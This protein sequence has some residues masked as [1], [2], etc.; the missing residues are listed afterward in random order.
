MRAPSPS[1]RCSSGGAVATEPGAGS[2]TE[3]WAEALAAWRIPPEVRAAAPED[4]HAFSPDLF[5][6]RPGPPPDTPTVRRVR[7]VL[8]ADGVLLDVGAAAGRLGLALCPPS[9]RLVA[10]DRDADALA[11]LR[12]DA[13]ARGIAVETVHGT[14]PE[15]AS[16]VEP[17]DVVLCAHV[18]YGV[19]DVAPFVQ[20]LRDRTLERLVL[21]VTAVHP[22]V[23][24]APL[25]E[26]FWGVSRPRGPDVDLL[27]EVLAEAGSPVWREDAAVPPEPVLDPAAELAFQRRR[28]CLPPEREPEVAAA[29]GSDVRPRVGRT[30]TLWRDVPPLV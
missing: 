9:G 24:L 21:E 29:L 4:P 20:A 19:P 25:Q 12:E 14:W 27:V 1:W 6:V 11:R 30:S 16:A 3:R 28:L 26:R 22:Q 2:A 23:P 17:A 13:A 5:R 8:P 15:V 10:V 18:L 7:E